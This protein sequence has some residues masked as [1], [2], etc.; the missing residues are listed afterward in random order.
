MNENGTTPE[1]NLKTR[2]HRRR[3]FAHRKTLPGF[4]KPSAVNTGI[5][6]LKNGS[7]VGTPD[8]GHET[9]SAKG[10]ARCSAVGAGPARILTVEHLLAATYALGI[11]NLSIDVHGGEIPVMDGSALPFVRFFKKAGLADQRESRRVYRVTEPIFCSKAGKALSVYP[12]DRFE[13]DYCLDYDYPYLRNQRAAFTVSSAVFEKEIAPARTFCTLEE[14]RQLKQKGLGLG[15]NAGN[16][17]VVSPDGSHRKRLRFP[18][19]CARHKILDII[20]DLS[21]LGFPILGKVIGIRSGHSLNRELA[22]AIRR[23]KDHGK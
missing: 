18:D 3:G 21:L 22:Q 4:F 10:A 16:N 8:G 15:G 17:I 19:E 6:F 9:P 23:Q 20:G 12:S 11:S 5:C 7:P 2:E 14:A 13:I 1:N